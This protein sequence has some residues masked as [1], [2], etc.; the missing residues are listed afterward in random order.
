MRQQVNFKLESSLAVSK[1]RL[2][3]KLTE[4]MNYKRQEIESVLPRLQ[5]LKAAALERNDFRGFRSALDR[6]PDQLGIIA[7]VKKASPSAGIIDPNFDP[8]RQARMYIDGG[9]SCM[10]I[11]TDEKYFQGHLSYL[12][13]ITK[14]SPIPLLRK[15]FT[16]HEVQIYEAVVAGA[17]AILLIVAGLNDEEL[18][19]L[20]GTAR[21]F[22][23]DVL[24]EVHNLQEMERALDLDKVDLVG[25]N[26]RNLK[27]FTTDL[28]ITEQ[29]VD[30]VPDDVLLVSES[31]IKSPAD[32]Q[33]VLNAGANAILV[34]ESLM[35]DNSPSETIPHYL[36]LVASPNDPEIIE[37]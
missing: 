11:L 27:T 8:V 9:A 2:V 23:L 31:G 22:Q 14:E 19:R 7:E 28:G 25:I 29:L 15:D 33:R 18:K 30:E 34:G 32:A 21:D 13:R 16:V 17:D 20:Y 5:K 24:V 1:V 35:R 12:S 10:S 6:G 37:A 3:D 4:I 36:E 26:N